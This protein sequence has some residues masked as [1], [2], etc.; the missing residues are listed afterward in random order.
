MMPAKIYNQEI[1]NSHFIV[2]KTTVVKDK[3]QLLQLETKHNY[4]LFGEEEGESE[5]SLFPDH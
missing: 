3:T 2:K 5:L 1:K 4:F